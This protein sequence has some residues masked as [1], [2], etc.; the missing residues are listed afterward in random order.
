MVTIES[1][2]HCEVMEAMKKKSLSRNTIFSEKP[3]A[4][5][6]D[7]ILQGAVGLM[8]DQ[9][10]SWERSAQRARSGDWGSKIGKALSES[11]ER[12]STTTVNGY[13]EMCERSAHNL[14]DASAKLR[15]LHATLRKQG[16]SLA[17]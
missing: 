6:L 9:A 15:G 5:I 8:E 4:E 14:S 11:G 10:W 7:H 17:S 1:G 2:S 3:G 16:L 12:P 13:V